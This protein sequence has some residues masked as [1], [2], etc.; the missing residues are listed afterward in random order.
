[1]DFNSTD[2]QSK[3]QQI[4]NPKY[5]ESNKIIIITRFR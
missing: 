4:L 2:P 3:M 1:M 5:V